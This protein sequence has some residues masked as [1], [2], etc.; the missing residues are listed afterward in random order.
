MLRIVTF[1]WTPTASR[2]VTYIAVGRCLHVDMEVDV[3]P[4][5]KE[6]DGKLDHQKVYNLSPVEELESEFEE[7]GDTIPRNLAEYGTV[8]YV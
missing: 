2:I 1:T 4:I 7:V 5:H 8:F 6:V 3:K